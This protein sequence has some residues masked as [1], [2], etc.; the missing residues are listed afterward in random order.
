M[1]IGLDDREFTGVTFGKI[2]K[3]RKIDEESPPRMNIPFGERSRMI[4][5]AD[6]IWRRASQASICALT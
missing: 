1:F 2:L 3:R 4:R 6:P 5:S